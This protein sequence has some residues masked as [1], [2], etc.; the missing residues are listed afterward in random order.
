[1]QAE[2]CAEQIKVMSTGHTVSMQALVSAPWP[3]RLEQHTK[4]CLQLQDPII[5]QGTHAPTKADML[6]ETYY[7]IHA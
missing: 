1:M 2:F 4:S 5:M 6:A 3:F 7:Q